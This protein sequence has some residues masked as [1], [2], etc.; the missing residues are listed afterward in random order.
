[1][2]DKLEFIRLPLALIAIFFVG[3]LIM[4]AMGAPYDA[5]NRV[6]S[7]VILQIHLALLWAAVGRGF[8]G[9][10]FGGSVAVAVMIAFA[11]QVLILLGT[12]GSYLAGADTYFNNPQALNSPTPVDFGTAM[13]AR[14]GGLVVNCI[15]SA[16]AGS[17]GYL[18]GK[19]LP[20]RR[21]IPDR[22]VV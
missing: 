5:G 9:Y 6:F 4:S 13:I 14:V 7:M 3:R 17:I 22:V 8:K 10:G 20:N 11:N 1:M 2:K 18:L 21:E 19:L 12:A 16:V 15:L